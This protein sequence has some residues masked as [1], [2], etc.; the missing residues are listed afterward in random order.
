MI[1]QTVLSLDDVASTVRVLER[2]FGALRRPAA[3]DA[4]D[5]PQKR[6]GTVKRLV[7]GG[8]SLVL[9][10]GVETSSN[11]QPVVEVAGLADA[12]AMLIDGESVLDP[13][14]HARHSCVGLTAGAST[15]E[16]L[17]ELVLGRLGELAFG[18]LEEV[19][20]ARK[21]VRSRLPRGLAS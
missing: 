8:A 2:C 15:P 1:S 13:A 3:A 6:R 12:D 11:A 10:I 5:G 19:T 4:C 17:D 18:E 9:V 7:C 14:L 21:H 20:A 16:K